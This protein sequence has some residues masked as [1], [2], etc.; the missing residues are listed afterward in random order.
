MN[1][2]PGSMVIVWHFG[3]LTGAASLIIQTGWLGLAIV[4]LGLLY[5]LG[6]FMTHAWYAYDPEGGM[7]GLCSICKVSLNF[8]G[9]PE[10]D[11]CGG[12]CLQCMAEAGDPDA[13][14]RIQMIHWV[15]S[16]RYPRG[17]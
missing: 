11:N 7:Q 3:L 4:G 16:G 14:S 15:K 10:T 2:F 9:R 5:W 12:D 8:P 13:I 6:G 17:Q 1:R